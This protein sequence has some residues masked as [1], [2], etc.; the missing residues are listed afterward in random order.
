MN[1]L[2][3]VSRPRNDPNN[4]YGTLPGGIDPPSDNLGQRQQR[5]QTLPHQSHRK[6]EADIPQ[7][8]VSGLVADLE[9]KEDTSNRGAGNG[10][11]PLDNNA[12][13]PFA[14][15]PVG[16]AATQVA[17]GS[18]THTAR[19]PL[20]VIFVDGGLSAGAIP[21]R[22]PITD[23]YT[24]LGTIIMVGTAPIGSS[25]IVDINKNGSTI[26]STSGNRPTIADGANSSGALIEPDITSLAYGD[27][28]TADID[29]VGSGTAGSNLSIC[30]VVTKTV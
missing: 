7:S 27:Y 26:Y 29:Q 5:G 9:S 19:L 14:N 20:S 3:K 13:V 18:H 16:S 30:V 4:R 25:L 21:S 2:G 12:D 6:I 8:S 23:T 17:Q 10:Y 28:L 24:I 1:G 15:L 11:A 22:L